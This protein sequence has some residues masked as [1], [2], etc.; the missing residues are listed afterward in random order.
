MKKLV[1]V[2][3]GVMAVAAI[4][5]AFD[6][7]CDNRGNYPRKEGLHEKRMDMKGERLEGYETLCEELDLT[8]KQKE[9]LEDLKDSRKK[10]MIVSRSDIKLLEIDRRNAMKDKDF[11]SAKKLTQDI[12]KLKQEMA[13]NKIEQDEKRWNVLTPEQQKKADEL[14]KAHHPKNRGMMKKNK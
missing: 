13:I 12:F 7:D 4:L 10:F 2:M 14:R 9:K 6:G 3:I 8:D 11:K 1:F 5:T